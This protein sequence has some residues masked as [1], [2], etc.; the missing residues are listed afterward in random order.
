MVGD[1]GAEIGFDPG[2][3]VQDVLTERR[4]P[5]DIFVGT[6][7]FFTD[8]N[9]AEV[10]QVSQWQ[11]V[12]VCRPASDSRLDPGG[13]IESEKSEDSG[14]SLGSFPRCGSLSNEIRD[15]LQ[16]V[17]GV[18]SRKGAAGD[19]GDAIVPHCQLRRGMEGH[20]TLSIA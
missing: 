16:R 9:A 11:G 2:N 6:G 13:E 10:G 8:Q 12:G 19:L 20:K 5:A 1:G 18:V 15:Q 14:G 3:Q 4:D 17:L 7:D